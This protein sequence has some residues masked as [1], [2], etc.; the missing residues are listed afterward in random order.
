MAAPVVSGV[1][2]L[3]M[4]YFPEL[5]AAEVK[6]VL[7]ESAVRY[8]GR[9]TTLP[10]EPGTVVPFDSLSATGSVVNAYE[11]VRRAL[12]GVQDR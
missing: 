9:N 11:A 10:G 2:A 6:E 8:G 1:A 4:A 7:L 3:L 12:G 5:G